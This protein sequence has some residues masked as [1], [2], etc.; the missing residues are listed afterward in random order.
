MATCDYRGLLTLTLLVLCTVPLR[1]WDSDDFELFDLVEEININFYEVFGIDKTATTSDVRKA[2]RRLSLQLHPDKNDA[3]DAAEKFRQIVSIYEVLKD[4]KKRERYNQVLVEGLPDWRQ[5]VY[6]YRR[7]R[8]MGIYELAVVLFIILTIGQ[9][10]VAWAIYVEKR[11]AME[12]F[13][14]SKKKK[15]KKKKKQ[16]VTEDEI[17]EDE[18]LNSIPIP[19]VLDLWPFQLAVYLF[20]TLYNLP[21]TLME[22]LEERKRRKEL[23]EAAKALLSEEIKEAEPIRKPKKRNQP[24][25]PE[26]S[27]EKYAMFPEPL[28]G[29]KEQQSQNHEPMELTRQKK[30]EWSDEDLIL[31]SKAV[32]KIPGGTHQRWEKIAEMVGR[33]VA[34]VTAKTKET[35]GNYTM[36]LNTAVQNSLAK[37]HGAGFKI[38]DYIIT[39]NED[40]DDILVP[41]GEDDKSESQI[42]KRHKHSNSVKTSER[43]LLIPR[44]LNE[45]I[46]VKDTEKSSLAPSP[47]GNNLTATVDAKSGEKLWTQNQQT[48]FEWALKQYPK[49]TEARWDK[50]AEHIPGKNKEDCI[51]RFKELAELVSRK[52]KGEQ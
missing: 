40:G 26:Y 7:A 47:M 52:K 12:E 25:L 11:L 2:Y 9:Y 39:Q 20:Y 35:K 22:W 29:R 27:S 42:R 23:E 24:E 44:S 31:L 4:E 18:E 5:P 10:F 32:N 13:L 1:S 34:E 19:K 50:V 49:G 43:T 37:S 16:I 46:A 41:C 28:S 36:L 21:Q 8:K 6:Y 33:T 17:N 30:G 15:E 48:I 38:N 45:S 3:E 51:L 14:S